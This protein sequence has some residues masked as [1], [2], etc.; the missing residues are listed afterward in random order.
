MKLHLSCDKTKVP[1]FFSCDW[2]DDKHAVVCQVIDRYLQKAWHTCNACKYDAKVA[3]VSE[4]SSR[5][6]GADGIDLSALYIIDVSLL[7]HHCRCMMVVQTGSTCVC[8]TAVW[9][10][11]Q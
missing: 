7:L 2:W 4:A 11:Q 8:C 6:R 9:H 1:R 3:D 10:L 5:R